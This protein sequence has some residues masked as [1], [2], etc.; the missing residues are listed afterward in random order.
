MAFLLT[1]HQLIQGTTPEDEVVVVPR[2]E[3]LSPSTYDPPKLILL[4]I[5][6]LSCFLCSA[7]YFLFY[8][9]SLFPFLPPI[10]YFMLPL[11]SC[12]PL[13]F[14]NLHYS[15]FDPL[16]FISVFLVTL[17]LLLLYSSYGLFF[18]SSLSG[19]HLHFPT[20][21]LLRSCNY[22]FPH[23]FPFIRFL[24]ISL[25]TAVLYLIAHI[26][27]LFKK[28]IPHHHYHFLF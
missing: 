15:L 12:L 6:F 17:S 8:S 26:P 4:F 1:F 5:L 7:S 16:L 18:L 2:N 23:R 14:L 21:R 24:L 9:S 10:L 22:S 27:L 19:L 3:I 13:S 11:L 25:I 20:N 28:F